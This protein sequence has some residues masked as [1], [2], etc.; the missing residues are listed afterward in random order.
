MVIRPQVPNAERDG[1]NHDI[2]SMRLAGRLNEANSQLNR[3][4]AAASGA[5]WRTLRD[6]EKLMSQMFPGEG[7]T[8]TAIS[9]RL[10]EINPVRHGLVKQVRTVRNE[11]SGKRVWFY[12]L[13]PNTG[14]GEPLH[15]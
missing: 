1:I 10:R 4:I 14:H 3:V 13:V 6:L 15:D 7:D 5:D 12:R 8:Q 11:D 9:A 2:R